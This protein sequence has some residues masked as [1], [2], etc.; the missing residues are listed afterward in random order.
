MKVSQIKELL[1]AYSDDDELMIAW[2]DREGFEYV[3]DK[4][5][6][7]EI[8][9]RAVTKFAHHDLQDFNEECHY[10]VAL[11]KDELEVSE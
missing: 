6:P 5:L 1:S 2:N 3:L 7:K 8:W 10:L 9:E 4:P 11:A